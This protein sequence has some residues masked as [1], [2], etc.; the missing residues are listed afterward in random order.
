MNVE[1]EHVQLELIKEIQNNICSLRVQS[2]QLCFALKSG[3]LFLI[4][5]DVP[6]DV[7]RCQVPLISS[8]NSVEKLITMWM[9]P[10]GKLLLL[11]TNFAR[12]Y[13]CNV[14]IIRQQQQKQ[15][16]Q[17]KQDPLDGIHTLK[18]LG[19]KGSDVKF[20]E[21][22]ENDRFLCGDASGQVLDVEINDKHGKQ[23][24]DAEVHV[25]C[26]SNKPIDG[27]FWN[28]TTE[29]IIIVS[30][31][32][33]MLWDNVKSLRHLR[34]PSEIEQFEHLPRDN[35]NRFT[36]FQETETFSWVT[37]P[38]VVF[39][40][41]GGNQNILNNAKVLLTVELPESTHDIK[42]IILTEFHIVL[43]RG[44]TILII[45][46][47]NNAVV[48]E[49][50]I[51]TQKSE[52]MIGLTADYSQNPPTF[53]CFSSSNIYEIIL[54]DE[55]K[56]VWRLMC[57]QREY[58]RALQLKGLTGWERENIYYKK[59]LHLLKDQSEPL[60]AAE[61]LGEADCVSVGSVAFQ[62]MQPPGDIEPLQIYLTSKLNK[63]D[64]K[65]QMQRILLSSWVVWNYMRQ[66]NEIEE[67]INGERHL[68][69][70]KHLNDQKHL[71]GTQLHVFLK[72]HLDCLDKKTV[73]QII[74]KQNRDQDLLYFGKL[75][76]DYEFVLSHWIRQANWF[77]ALNVLLTMQDP[78]SAYT[79][80][81]VLLVNAPEETIHVWM[82]MTNLNP[83]E[84]IPSLLT[85]FTSYQR[86]AR[87]NKRNYALVYLN[88]CVDEHEY[89]DPILY[90]TALYMLITDND[91]DNEHHGLR[92]IEFL[93]SH[94]DKYD[95]NF[96][97]RLSIK[98]HKVRVSI[99]LYTQLKLYKDAV[100]LAL[101]RQMIDAAKQVVETSELDSNVKLK[102][103]LWREIAKAMLY[104]DNGN[105]DIK[106]TVRCIIS[107]SHE[108]LEIKDLLPLLDEF[109][110]IANLKDE[111]IRSLEKHGQS[112]SRIST[113]IQQSL[114]MKK[115]IAVEIETFKER[116][117]TLEP[118]ISCSSC[119][120]LLQTRKFLVFPCGHCFHTDCLIKAILNSNDY[121]FK[122]LIVNF[123]RRLAKDRNSVKPQ[124]LELIITR[125]CCLCSDININTIDDYINIDENEAAK[126]EI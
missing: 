117:R 72:S 55:A 95:S 11:K 43:L 108:L 29:K 111:L 76:K 28:S 98:F 41:L 102:K 44:A 114:R 23:R 34:E 3:L 17:Q 1:I 24:S 120:K 89:E 75:V 73:Y 113:Q 104:R 6:S 47:L 90:N 122:S 103:S 22:F 109:T 66:L 99:Y 42:D 78:E 65:N 37:K 61:S 105:Q 4:D 93:D 39:G 101:S 52:N 110:T 14:D 57:E 48:F 13:L 85:Y 96:I 126:W 10:N 70:V 9:S 46:Q 56:A 54:H 86:Q 68:D 32:K 12:Y 18:K 36:S 21:W 97:L 8:G 62:F 77:E 83:V 116:Y 15:Q 79:Y 25:V 94:R 20:V 30:E 27:I 2:N 123:Q 31:N 71:L 81:S 50:S 106:H 82:K 92:V 58:D 59:G 16:K 100:D 74:S 5:L 51:W 60:K 19:K 7:S 49:E 45:N 63:L 67:E 87:K 121:N 35:G 124:E 40:K 125:K 115:D 80:A 112:M 26:Q 91:E 38:G 118:G 69:D 33:I 107:E 88:W 119:E 53:W 84:L 64:S